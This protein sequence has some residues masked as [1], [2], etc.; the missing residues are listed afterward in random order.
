MFT[1]GDPCFPDQSGMRIVRYTLQ[2]GL[3]R[4]NATRFGGGHTHVSRASHRCGLYGIRYSWAT[5]G[6][7]RLDKEMAK[8]MLPRTASGADCTVYAIVGLHTAPTERHDVQYQ[9]C[10]QRGINGIRYNWLTK[11][12]INTKT[13]RPP[14]DPSITPMPHVMVYA[15]HALKSTT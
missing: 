2:L 8:R 12:R 11:C 3:K 6:A 5:S 7:E 10:W 4:R 9:A 1:P 15:G 14:P 13:G